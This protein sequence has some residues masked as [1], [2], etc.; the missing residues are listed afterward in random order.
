MCVR[1]CQIEAVKAGKGGESCRI[2]LCPAA[3]AQN[4]PEPLSRNLER[5]RRNLSG[6]G[7]LTG[8]VTAASPGGVPRLAPRANEQ[9]RG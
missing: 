9:V 2:S 1:S 4:N 8:R 6:C 5:L 7:A 3:R